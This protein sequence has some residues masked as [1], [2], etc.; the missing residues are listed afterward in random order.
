MG[1]WLAGVDHP[2]SH[3]L[4]SSSERTTTTAHILNAYL[5]GVVFRSDAMY[6]FSLSTLLEAFYE[7]ILVNSVEEISSLAIVGHNY[8][9]SD[10]LAYLSGFRGSKSLSTL[11]LAELEFTGNWRDL[12]RGSC[13]LLQRSKPKVKA[14]ERDS[15]W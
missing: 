8:A 15:A 11:G 1:A 13:S 9:I 2:P 12:G 6:T 4:C 3:F 5:G 7:E 10:L 14:D